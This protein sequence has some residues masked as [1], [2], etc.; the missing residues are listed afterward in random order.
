MLR[1]KRVLATD[2]EIRGSKPFN[3]KGILNASSDADAKQRLRDLITSSYDLSSI[4]TDDEM[5]MEIN[6]DEATVSEWSEVAKALTADGTGEA[7]RQIGNE[8]ARAIRH[9]VEREGFLR[10]LAQHNDLQQGTEPRV[11]VHI[12]NDEVQYSTSLEKNETQID[13]NEIQPTEFELRTRISVDRIDIQRMADRILRIKFDKAEAQMIKMED[14]LLLDS[15]DS[16]IDDRQVQSIKAESYTGIPPCRLEAGLDMVPNNFSSKTIL[17]SANQFRYILR[18][19]NIKS[20]LYKPVM[21]L[22]K[23]RKGTLACFDGYPVMTD[24]TRKENRQVIEDT[25]IYFFGPAENV[26]EYTDQGDVESKSMPL[27]HKDRR[28]FSWQFFEDMSIV[29]RNRGGVAKMVVDKW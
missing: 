14:R 15:V 6:D 4:V 19:P 17:M 20:E 16:L 7:A 24:L 25:E 10:Q 2:V 22:E 1:N 13:W 26:A 18:S 27:V 29:P 28:V 11:R 23:M 8:M 21:S 5:E 12:E 3:S 9:S